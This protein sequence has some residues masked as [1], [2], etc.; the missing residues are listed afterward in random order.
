MTPACK[1]KNQKSNGEKSSWK[2]KIFLRSTEEWLT[3]E[4]P[5]LLSTCKLQKLCQDEI[6]LTYSI[7]KSVNFQLFFGLGKRREGF[8][9]RS[10]SG[11]FK[12]S[13][14]LPISFKC[15]III[16]LSLINAFCWMRQF[17]LPDK[18]DCDVA[19]FKLIKLFNI[20]IYILAYGLWYQR[21]L[22]NSQYWAV[23]QSNP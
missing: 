7:Y 9:F 5:L 22:Q 17:P 4:G 23:H 2:K 13:Q 20:Y 14:L 19:S 15:C 6:I 21:L 8:K 16:C 3:N 1:Y 18:F 12:C 10:S 11:N